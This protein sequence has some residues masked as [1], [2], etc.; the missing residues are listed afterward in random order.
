MIKSSFYNFLQM[1]ILV[2]LVQVSISKAIGMTST[3]HIEKAGRKKWCFWAILVI[4]LVA[5][6][7]QQAREDIL[8]LPSDGA[9]AEAELSKQLKINRDA[10]FK[11]SNERIRLDAASVML[12]TE[13]PLARK[14]LLEA[15]KQ[16]ESVVARVAVCKA[17]SQAR[18]G[19][20]P[21][22]N[23]E[24][25]IQPLFDI[26]RTETDA[27][28]RLAAEALLIFEY[29][30]IAQRLEEVGTDASLPVQVRLNAIYALRLQPD[31]RAIF[32]LI[33]LLDDPE[34]LVAVEAENALRLLGTPIGKD[35]EARKQIRSELK[36]RGRDEFFRD[37]LIRQEAKMRELKA[38]RQQWQ[39]R[40]LSALD[41]IYD[42]I[43][44][45][46]TKS[47]F[48]AVHLS[49]SEV[50]V[51]LWALERI[52]QWRVGTRSEL[53]TDEL[54]PIL[55]DLI[56]D[57]DRNV[58]LKTA[59]LLSLMGELN[60]AERLLEQLNVEQDG[61]V[62]V[63]FFVALGGACYY[64][65]LPNS[66]ISVG[67]DVR[68]Q[69]LELASEYL[70]KQ[71]PEKAQKGAEVIKKLLEQDGLASGE[72]NRY[73]G[74]LAERYSRQASES[75][76]ALRGELLRAMAGLCG[77]S[78]YKA[79]S[80]RLFRPLFEEA[81]RDETDMAREAAIDGLIYIDKTRA[82]KILRKDFVNDSSIIVREK[83]IQLAGEVGGQDDL[84]W[85]AEKIEPTA[86]GELA[87]QAM[88]KIFRGSDATVLDKW[89][90]KLDSPNTKA[91]LSDEQMLSFL[92][93]AERKAVGEGKAD[94]IKKVRGK[95]AL[96]YRKRGEFE[97]A[98]EYWGMIREVAATPEEKEAILAELLDVYLRWPNF[99]AAT[100]LVRN[101]LLEKDLEPDNVIVLSLDNYFA[102]PPATA[103]P[104]A[105]LEALVDI[106]TSLDRPIW[107]QQV[108]RW[109]KRLGQVQGSDE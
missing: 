21:I 32:K 50:I 53:P 38:E 11:G 7:C 49:G 55:V 54:G 30:Q 109:T 106:N 1:R 92:E 56:S 89:I 103:D 41:E 62:R 19:Q 100:Q 44:D 16:S 51:K 47:K 6:G 65:F 98:A 104:N 72:V 99:E 68:K 12:F 94:V 79:E 27:S 91:R 70:S 108:G 66:G 107:Q 36:R 20:K 58:R 45:D 40:Y 102:D 64:A 23:K 76:G 77:Q 69:T 95:L 48:L 93:M 80:T 73:L 81:L 85:L 3:R 29:E 71:D 43:D 15:L 13:D 2:G 14:I 5:I 74:L 52:S 57:Q 96:L 67:P 42:G 25:F 46:A 63:E 35:A 83:L 4:L 84:A 90:D 33:D 22:R 75:E 10:L 39:E 59:K 105:I 26:L 17:L 101:S 9:I 82:L 24:D 87:W 78:V 86:E 18:T 97:R 8:A 28:A 60:S 88:L 34:S 31:M 61:E 37:L